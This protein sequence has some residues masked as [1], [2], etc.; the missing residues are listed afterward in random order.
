MQ[1]GSL[2]QTNTPS[3]ELTCYR[4]I[5]QTPPISRL[6]LQRCTSANLCS[7]IS[8]FLPSYHDAIATLE[9]EKEVLTRSLYNGALSRFIKA[10]KVFLACC[11]GIS[12]PVPAY[13][14]AGF[15]PLPLGRYSM[16]VNCFIRT[17]QEAKPKRGL[18]SPQLIHLLAGSPFNPLL[19]TVTIQSFGTHDGLSSLLDF[20]GTKALLQHLFLAVTLHYGSGGSQLHM[21][22]TKIPC[23]RCLD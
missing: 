23:C 10:G 8:T 16:Y 18:I 9:E 15:A 11:P 13:M 22:Q 1:P 3:F 20:E 6:I 5:K 17:F 12:L 14:P 7:D 4:D 2:D 19:C 21:M